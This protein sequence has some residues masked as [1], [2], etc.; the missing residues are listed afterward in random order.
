MVMFIFPL[1]VFFTVLKMLLY[2]I[3]V[4]LW[5]LIIVVLL[6]LAGASVVVAFY[7]I[8]LKIGGV[9]LKPFLRELPPLLLENIWINSAIDALAFNIRYCVR[10]YKMDRKRLEMSLP[11]LSQ[12]MFDGNCYFLMASA[13]FIA[14]DAGGEHH[15]VPASDPRVPGHLPVARRPQPAGRNPGRSFDPV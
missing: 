4:V 11:A 14:F 12:T 6:I 10:H 3:K 15:L 1:F 2:G 13:I 8:R 5:P 7:L 9:R